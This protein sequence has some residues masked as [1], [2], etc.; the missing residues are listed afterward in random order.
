MKACH[1]NPLLPSE[2]V[3]ILQQL[4]KI[5]ENGI[6]QDEISLSFPISSSSSSISPMNQ[7][8][9]H[10]STPHSSTPHN[11]PHN[12]YNIDYNK[13]QSTPHNLYNI[14]YTNFHFLGAPLDTVTACGIAD[15]ILDPST[16][17]NSRFFSI[18]LF[19]WIIW[20]INFMELHFFFLNI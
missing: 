16:R 15:G 2:V 7:S 3:P 6:I 13:N 4:F 8:T 5:K 20:W 17:V 10:S 1:L 19:V 14:D 9:P 12:L 11:T 18:L